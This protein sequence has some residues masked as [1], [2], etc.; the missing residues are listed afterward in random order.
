MRMDGRDASDGRG[1]SED[2]EADRALQRMMSAREAWHRSRGEPTELDP[3]EAERRFLAARE[4]WLAQG[5][6]P[7]EAD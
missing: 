4:A 3:G 2:G 6:A 5:G 7:A 1:G